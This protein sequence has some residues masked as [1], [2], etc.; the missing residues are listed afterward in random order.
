MPPLIEIK[1]LAANIATAKKGIAEV[2]GAAASF[3]ASSSALVAELNEVTAQ[4]EQHRADLRFEAETLGNGPEEPEKPAVKPPAVPLQI[5]LEPPPTQSA[6]S[7][8]ASTEP[9]T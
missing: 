7:A 5:A 4:L 2:R 9:R 1:G 8:S 6:G 3:G